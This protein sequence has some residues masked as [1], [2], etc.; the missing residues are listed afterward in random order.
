MGLIPFLR[1]A[2]VA[3]AIIGC[4]ALYIWLDHVYFSGNREAGRVDPRVVRMCAE[5]AAVCVFASIASW[6]IA[7]F[8]VTRR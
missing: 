6:K 2:I 4:V 3:S 7:N 1:L 8:L 5:V